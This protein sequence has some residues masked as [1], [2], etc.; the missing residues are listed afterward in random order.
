M[1]TLDCKSTS[2]Q[3]LKY[4]RHVVIWI[5]SLFSPTSRRIRNMQSVRDDIANP[6]RAHSH[7][8]HNF[9]NSNFIFQQSEISL[10]I[11]WS[12]RSSPILLIIELKMVNT[13]WA[14]SPISYKH[15]SFWCPFLDPH[16]ITCHS[17]AGV[18]IIAMFELG[19][20]PY[21]HDHII[22]EYV[23]KGSVLC[24]LFGDSVRPSSSK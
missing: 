13:F 19:M 4:G 21:T 11:K 15:M 14:S 2:L 8:S 9:W 5:L 20:S 23:W 12:Y 16:L 10:L 3:V 17:H 1:G 18:Q 7:L 6:N 22:L 24:W